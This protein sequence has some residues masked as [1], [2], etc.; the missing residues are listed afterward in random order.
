MATRARP[1]T[2]QERTRTTEQAQA[3][4][5]PGPLANIPNLVWVPV[6][7]GG[8]ILIIGGLGWFLQQPWL[9]ASLGPTAYLLAHSPSQPSARPY[10]IIVGHCLA[11]TMAFL[12]LA[13]LGGLDAPSLFVTHE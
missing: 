7:V 11:G 3:H 1:I 8:L 6:V 9:F 5:T 4:S 12:A 2:W 10:N 13:L